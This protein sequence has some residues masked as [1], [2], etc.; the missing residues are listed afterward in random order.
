M[1][2]GGLEPP[3]PTLSVRGLPSG[4]P[5]SPFFYAGSQ[6]VERRLL[7]A[8]LG[9]S[10]ASGGP[11]S[12]ARALVR[13]AGAERHPFRHLAPLAGVWGLAPTLPNI[14]EHRSVAGSVPTGSSPHLPLVISQLPG[15]LINWSGREG[16]FAILRCVLS[17]RMRT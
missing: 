9:P 14:I 5:H 6:P 16:R 11:R 10:G 15:A 3:T 7:L 12:K 4:R 17:G 2:L 8:V 13:I 1:R